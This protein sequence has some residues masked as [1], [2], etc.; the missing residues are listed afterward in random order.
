M[1]D[2][3]PLISVVVLTYNS[4]K[5]VVETLDSIRDQTYPRI[6]L[7]VGDDCSTDNTRDVVQ[8]WISNNASRF[9]EALLV[10]TSHN[11]GVTMNK[12]NAYKSVR[13]EWVKGIAA[14]DRLKP[15][16]LERFLYHANET[17]KKIFSCQLDLFSGSCLDLKK[18]QD[19]YDNYFR[20]I[21]ESQDKQLHRLLYDTYFIPGPSLFYSMSLYWEVNGCDTRFSMWEEYSFAYRILKAGYRVTPVY[22]KLVEYRY[23]ENSLCRINTSNKPR[24]SYMK[25]MNDKRLCFWYYQ[26]WR[27]L[28]NGHFCDAMNKASDLGRTC[29]IHRHWENRFLVAMSHFYQLFSPDWYCSKFRKLFRR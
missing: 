24:T 2:E 13:G 25:Y 6:Q 26:F 21:C 10:K 12:T 28:F 23:E 19:V 17:G 20:C 14:D 9:E 16:C 27:W 15:Q 5:T 3:T 18:G 29:F 22:E 4:S 8:S 11:G 1:R 7:V